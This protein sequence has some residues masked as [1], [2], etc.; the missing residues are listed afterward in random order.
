MEFPT[1][2]LE[3]KFIEEA[4]AHKMLGLKGHRAVGGLRDLSIMLAQ[5]RQSKH[6]P[7]LWKIS[8]REISNKNSI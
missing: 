1:P 5:C 6:L 3:A 8:I 4:K 2:E 7:I